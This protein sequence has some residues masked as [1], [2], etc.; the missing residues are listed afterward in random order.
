M[1]S[2]EVGISDWSSDVCSCDLVGVQARIL[3]VVRAPAIGLELA[4]AL[5][6]GSCGEALALV[7]LRVAG[8]GEFGHG[9]K[10]GIR[11]W[12]FGIGK[13]GYR[14]AAASRIPNPE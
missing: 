14:K 11:D 9:L 4:H 8:E 10:S 2:Y 3:G 5:R 1:W 12:G 7:D 13:G 6:V